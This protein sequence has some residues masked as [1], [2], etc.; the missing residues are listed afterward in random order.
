MADKK[1]NTKITKYRRHSSFFNIGTLIFGAIFVYMIICM[2]IYVTAEHVTTYEVTAG[3]ISGNYRYTALALK[4]EHVIQAPQSGKVT[5]Y[6][7]ESAKA[8]SGMTVCAIN[9]GGTNQ[10]ASKDV[11]L[12]SED[13]S[14][15]TDSMAS[16]TRSFDDSSYQSV[17]NF[18]ADLESYILQLSQTGD[19]SGVSLMNQCTAPESGFVVYAVDG[20][21]NLTE[22]NINS[23]LFNRNSYQKSS[24][25]L[26]TSVKAGDDLYKQVTSENWAL[27][28]P[29]DKSLV[30]E[31]EDRST[32][33]FRFLKDD[34]TFSA[35]FSIINNIGEYF[36][37]ISLNNSLVRYVSDRYLEIELLMDREFG[38]KI[39]ASAIAEKV[40]Y[41]I[42]ED[43]VIT[44]NDTENEI[45]L[46]RET[47][48]KD[49]SS[50]VKYV[51][52]TVYSK[53]DGYYLVNTDLF[54]EGDYVQM[55]DT[56]KKFQIQASNTETIQGVYNI[57]KGY[58]VFR[59]VTI[60]DANEEFCIVEPN[61]IYGL[62]AH[63]HIVLDADTVDT[64]DIVY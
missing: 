15:L 29:M 53:E 63:D 19:G 60:N 59:E 1:G 44:N 52:A 31:L 6:A 35:G 33:R 22:S 48:N 45:T 18:K 42:P 38:L 39:P 36:G 64:D 2:I 37:K 26:N 57:N 10:S 56:S 34:I 25:R 62:A 30:T 43:Y 23:D 17:Y 40:F 11:T 32:I 49:G 51:T 24:L 5:Y 50:S 58:A 8:S 61:N 13:I 4:E 16:F 47:F 3:S 21:E 7:R 46:L 9:E 12:T 41:R 55:V 27:Y 28:F 54:K 14:R 20:M